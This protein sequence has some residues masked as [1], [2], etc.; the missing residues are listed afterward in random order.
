[1]F[2]RALRAETR[3]RARA[4]SRRVHRTSEKVQKWEKKWMSI[5]DTSML[6]YKWVPV[7]EDDHPQPKKSGFARAQSNVLAPTGG[8]IITMSSHPPELRTEE[9]P[10]SDSAISTAA[11]NQPKPDQSPDENTNDAEVKEESN[12]PISNDAPVDLTAA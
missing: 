12:D 6:V 3:S 9:K 11:D 4:D 8:S 10:L 5:K 2:A 1:M 7:I